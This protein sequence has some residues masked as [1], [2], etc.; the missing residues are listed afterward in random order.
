VLQEFQI[1][2]TGEFDTKAPGKSSYAAMPKRG[3]RQAFTAIL[4]A[5]EA[6]VAN[7]S[8]RTLTALAV[9]RVS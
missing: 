7:V 5:F 3:G 9:A 6:A 4:Q 8:T 1:G 2:G